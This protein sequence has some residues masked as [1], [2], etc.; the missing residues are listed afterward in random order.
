MTELAGLDV[1][2]VGISADAPA[3]VKSFHTAQKLNFPLLSD[4]GAD[5][6]RAYGVARS[7]ANMANRVTFVVDPDGVV[8][9]VEPNVSPAGHG[10]SLLAEI[11]RLR[12]DVKQR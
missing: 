1:Q 12:T 6:I 3:D 11:R 2:V 9:F 4:A 5:T 10:A 7:G 8:R